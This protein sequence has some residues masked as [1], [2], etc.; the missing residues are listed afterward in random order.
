M[1]SP[2]C[3]GRRAGE[4]PRDARL[5]GDAV[6][7]PRVKG[8]GSGR[9]E[10]APAAPVLSPH[11]AAL[12]L[13]PGGAAGAQGAALPGGRCRLS[14]SRCSRGAGS[15]ALLRCFRVRRAGAQTPARPGC[16]LPLQPVRAHPPEPRPP[17]P[18]SSS[19]SRKLAPALGSLGSRQKYTLPDLP[20]DYGALEPHI[21]AQIMQL[22]HKKHHA[23]YVN[24]LNATEDKYL[25]ALEKGRSPRNRP[26]GARARPIGKCSS[27]R[28]NRFAG[29]RIDLGAEIREENAHFV[30][31]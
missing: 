25:E 16:P 6:P 8:V 13:G 27:L 31:K 2:C 18:L 23:A 7:A 9:A 30:G 29:S 28:Q 11:S 14:A 4:A 15:A 12:A 26:Q 22:H 24:N 10:V 3:P 20:Y 5:S 17:R 21:N 1:A 19:T